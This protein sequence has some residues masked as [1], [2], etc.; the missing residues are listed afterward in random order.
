[1]I[2]TRKSRFV[3]EVH[4]PN[5]ELRSSAD[6]LTEFQQENLAYDSRRL[7]SRRLVR[8]PSAFLQAKRPVSRKEPFLPPSIFWDTIR[9]V[10]LAAFSKRGA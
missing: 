3:D 4:F 7:A 8:T 10:L 1:M 2:S 9:P 5:A 6:S